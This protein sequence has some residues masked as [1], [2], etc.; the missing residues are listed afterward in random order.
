MVM[1]LIV[2]GSTILFL[3]TSG[4]GK[5]DEGKKE[6]IS[7][8][9]SSGSADASL[10]Q[11]ES[12]LTNASTENGGENVTDPDGTEPT[13][14]PDDDEPEE[15]GTPTPTPR[16]ASEIVDYGNYVVFDNAGYEM[17]S[18]V[19]STSLSYAETINSAASKYGDSVN[20]YDI[21]IP[22]SSAIVFPEEYFD[23]IASSN[24]RDAINTISAAFSDNVHYVDI[25]DTL[26][27]HRWDYIYFRTDHHWTALGAYYAYKN[28]MKAMGKTAESLDDYETKEFE[29]FI[30]S[31]YDDTG[32]QSLYDNPDTVIAYL[33]HAD[34]D[35]W[36]RGTDGS[37]FNWNI[38]SDVNNASA[39]LKYVTFSAGDNDFEIVTNNELSDGSSCVVVKES[40]GN[41]FIPFLVDHYQYVYVVD[42]RYYTGNLTS[43]IQDNGVDD[44][45]FINN[46]SMTR[47]KYLVGKIQTLIDG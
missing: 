40:F 33:P 36:V 31:F 18:F 17:Y 19:E 14:V 27:K 9:G 3:V 13:P 44:L 20:V 16:P 10:D 7:S 43:L 2:I 38:I 34:N 28:L 21:I 5:K 35:L 4:G 41:A 6:A 45:I 29:G 46:V 30:G 23:L 37:E 12:Q 25:Y 15:P 39:N 26:Y 1:V 47:N 24:Q 32:D 22:L 42:Y 8:N 11:L